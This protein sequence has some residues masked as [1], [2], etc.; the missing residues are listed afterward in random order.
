MIKDGQADNK[1][2][3][4]K[5]YLKLVLFILVLGIISFGINLIV[6]ITNKPSVAKKKEEEQKINLDLAT[7]ATKG[8]KLWQ[9]NFDERLIKEKHE[10][11]SQHETMLKTIKN[12]EDKLSFEN[13]KSSQEDEITVLKEQV[14]WLR[15]ELSSLNKPHEFKEQEVN[16]TSMRIAEQEKLEEAKDM[17]NYIPAGSFVSGILRG[18]VS[19]STSA[20]APSEPTPIF[21]AVTG[22]G[23]LPKSFKADL[24]TCRLIG[25]SYGNLAN[26]RIIARVETL[27]CT[28]SDTG[29]VTETDIAG[30]VHSMD[31]KNGIKGTV[32]SMSDKHLKNAFIGGVLSG[33]AQTGKQGDTLLFNPSL[34]AVSQ[35]QNS[36]SDKLGQNGLVGLGNAA[37]KIADYHLK[38]AEATSPV[39]EVPGGAKVTVFFSKG[40][41]LGSMNVKDRIQKE[42]K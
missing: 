10:R 17:N 13:E 2:T 19:A 29:L 1:S 35:K 22:Y 23:D 15:K 38:M 18:G 12:L 41:F 14:A 16:I 8:D 34:G 40:V 32:I 28:D 3:K 24:A 6:S 39:I 27:S 31:S 42:R 11:D 4:K 9:N 26:E 25:S 30:V 33:F 7:Y 37:E 21:I 20:S 36:I 5:Q